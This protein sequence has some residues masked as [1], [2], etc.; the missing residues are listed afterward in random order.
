[1]LRAW[2][3]LFGALA[4]AAPAP[5]LPPEPPT[6]VRAGGDAARGKALYETRCGACHAID[7]NGPGPRHR[8]VLGRLAGTQPG[9]DY[10]PAL[11]RFAKRWTEARLDRWLENPS[12]LVP[13]NKM[14]V[15]LAPSP[16]D[17]RDLIA[18]LRA[19]ASPQ[20]PPEP[21]PSK[22]GR[23]ARDR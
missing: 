22:G 4:A 1:M 23:D 20:P 19:A 13:G 6:R 21:T 12:A 7:D 14:V 8:G 3:L 11:R 17:R 9:Y 18:Y 10:S 15:Q 2:P 16:L 5:T